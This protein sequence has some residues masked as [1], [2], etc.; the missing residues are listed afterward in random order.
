MIDLPK[1]TLEFFD[2]DE[3]RAR[4]FYEKYS[5]SDLEGN[6]IEKTPLDLDLLPYIESRYS[7]ALKE[8]KESMNTAILDIAQYERWKS[9]INAFPKK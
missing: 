9:F 4:I 7:K 2:N 3:L 6:R 1:E 5:L 8:I